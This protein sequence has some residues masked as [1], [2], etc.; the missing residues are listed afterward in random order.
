MAKGTEFT[1][2]WFVDVCECS[3]YGCLAVNILKQTKHSLLLNI[4]NL[5]LRDKEEDFK[6]I[7]YTQRR[8]KLRIDPSVG[9]FITIPAEKNA[10]GYEITWKYDIYFKY[11]VLFD[12]LQ[13]I[14]RM[15][16]R[17]ILLDNPFTN[18]RRKIFK[19]D[20]RR[21]RLKWLP[22][23]IKTGFPVEIK[24]RLLEWV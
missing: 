13:D 15:I 1:G 4:S 6:Q 16:K 19:Y 11:Q 21:R 12:S 5:D 18:L 9:Y 22:F 23:L 8:F 20:E 7:E 17:P 14:L 2:K 3:K 24:H 10:L